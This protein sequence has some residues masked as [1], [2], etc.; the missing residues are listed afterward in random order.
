LVAAVA[1]V[2]RRV[3]VT[4]VRSVAEAADVVPQAAVLEERLDKETL[5][6]AVKRLAAA[7]VAVLVAQERFPAELAVTLVTAV[8]GFPLPLVV[9]L[10]LM[11][12][13]AAV[14]GRLAVPEEL[15]V[16]VAEAMVRFHLLAVTVPRVQLTPEAAAEAAVFL[17]VLPMVTAVRVG[18]ESLL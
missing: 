7:A 8:R 1:E 16:L 10:F 6:L 4:L 11:L 3:T 18:A 9:L 15:A 2:V 14:A 17:R 12:A 5:V 13:A